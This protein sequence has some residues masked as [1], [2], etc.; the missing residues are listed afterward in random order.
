MITLITNYYLYIFNIYYFSYICII[1]NFLKSITVLFFII[2]Q[3]LIFKKNQLV[4][5][6]FIIITF[7][8]QTNSPFINKN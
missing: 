5:L 8:Y 7:F 6:T 1:A 2:V 3:L 4:C